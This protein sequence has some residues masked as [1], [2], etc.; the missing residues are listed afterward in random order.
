[1]VSLLLRGIVVLMMGPGLA[2]MDKY[3]MQ[4]EQKTD[5]SSP[6]NTYTTNHQQD[7]SIASLSS[8]LK[9]ATGDLS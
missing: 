6:F 3:L 2:F 5:L 4:M 7:P 1:M 9:P 8:S